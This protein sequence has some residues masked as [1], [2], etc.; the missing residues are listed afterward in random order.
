MDSQ[1]SGFSVPDLTDQVVPYEAAPAQVL[2]ARLAWEEACTALRYLLVGS[3]RPRVAVPPEWASLVG[4]LQPATS[5]PFCLGNFPQ[6]VRNLASL[7]DQPKMIPATAGPP[8]PESRELADW[9]Q[10]NCR[11]AN[12][13]H[14]LVAAAILRLTGRLNEAGDWL[15]KHEPAKGDPWRG[16]WENEAAGLAWHRGQL[17]QAAQLWIQQAD[18]VP[19]LFNRGLAA[20]AKDQK[21]LA[22]QSLTRAVEQLP[23]SDGWHHLGRLYL[24]LA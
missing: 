8:L 18:S 23:A 22:R 19:V 5:V 24:A 17:D 10:K 12:G 7:L 4:A 16:V 11:Q 9:V 6:L 20:L 15:Q 1:A 14:P 2:D 21:E 3:E 13:P